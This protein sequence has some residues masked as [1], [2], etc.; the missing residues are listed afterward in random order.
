MN[1]YHIR[2]YVWVALCNPRRT[3][4]PV[5]QLRT[6]IADTRT[7]K[8]QTTRSITYGSASDLNK[9]HHPGSS[10][11][12]YASPVTHVV[13]HYT[14]GLATHTPCVIRCH[15]TR[16]VKFREP[17]WPCAGH[18]R[19]QLLSCRTMTRETERLHGCGFLAATQ[20]IVAVWAHSSYTETAVNKQPHH[21]YST[22]EDSQGYG[23]HL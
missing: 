17:S 23:H 19:P 14:H 13:T 18:P 2:A 8:S 5:I 9:C 1:V 4:P 11:M 6:C 10:C 7:R 21:R 20:H 15:C 16:C 22:Q 3:S 12:S